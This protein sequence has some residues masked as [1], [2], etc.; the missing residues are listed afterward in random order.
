MKKK[1]KSHGDISAA[2]KKKAEKKIHELYYFSCNEISARDIFSCLEEVFGDA[3]DIW[4]E[5]DLAELMLKN[6]SLIFQNAEQCFVDPQ[7]QK[8]FEEEGIKSKYQISFEESDAAEVRKAMERLMGRYGGLIGSD[9][10]DFRPSYTPEEL[11]A[12]EAAFPHS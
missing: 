5:L 3:I 6:D 9:T 7:D 4:P 12:F 8:W 1:P 2:L 11:D 10:D